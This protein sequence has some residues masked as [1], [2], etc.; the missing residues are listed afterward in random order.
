MPS[1]CN[2][3][4]FTKVLLH[5]SATTCSHL[6]GAQCSKKYAALLCDLSIVIGEACRHVEMPL[7]TRQ[8][9]KQMNVC[10]R[11]TTHEDSNFNQ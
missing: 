5:V 4:G 3:I 11:I 7:H 9:A 1:K 10:C 8:H 6:Q 2:N